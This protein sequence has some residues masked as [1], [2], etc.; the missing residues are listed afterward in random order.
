MKEPKLTVELV[1]PSLHFINLRSE[2][3]KEEWDVIRKYCYVK[4]QYRC[5]ICSGV[6][7]THPVE[8]HEMWYYDD[9][10]HLQTLV[11]VIALCPMCHA[12]KHWGLSSMRGMEYDCKQHLIRVNNWKA[13]QM[14]R[15]LDRIFAKHEE[16]SLH[17]WTQDIS[18][19]QELLKQKRGGVLWTK[20]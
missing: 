3:S 18:L 17:H 14:N 16:R 10:K 19:A 7:N 2:L 11:G 9:K 8:C 13:D 20:S 1:P 5:E 12:V 4:A 15:Y 6:G